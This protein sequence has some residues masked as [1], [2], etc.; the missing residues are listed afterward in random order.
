MCQHL[1]IRAVSYTHLDVY[2]RQ[3][4]QMQIALADQLAEETERIRSAP[5]RNREN[6]RL[7]DSLKQ[8]EKQL[9]Q[10]YDA[11]DSLYLDWKSSEITQDEY[12]RLKDRIAQQIQQLET[13]ISCLL[14]TSRC[15]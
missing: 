13:N 5:V 9:K 1:R 4:L 15:V 8:T 12:R 14:Y 10:Y 2:K 7:S 3:A 6:K 11:S